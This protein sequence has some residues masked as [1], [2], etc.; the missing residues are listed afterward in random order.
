MRC[1]P[2]DSVPAFCC[3]RSARIGNRSW[4]CSIRSLRRAASGSLAPPRR[5]LSSTVRSGNTN[6]SDGIIAIPA[7]HVGPEPGPG[8][9]PP[10]G[11]M[12][13]PAWAGLS[14]ST[15]RIVVVL[16]EPLW[17]RS[18]TTSPAPTCR[19]TSNTTCLRP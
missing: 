8:D 18:V 15:V 7:L 3:A 1:W 2:P 5:R 19:L 10:A 14:P 16:P 17:P 9:V 12:T 11:S 6:R 4:T 13:R